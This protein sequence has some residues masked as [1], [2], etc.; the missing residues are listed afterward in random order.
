M[1]IVYLHSFMLFIVVHVLM[2]ES[3]SVRNS[4]TVVAQ[5]ADQKR[6]RKHVGHC[7][8]FEGEKNAPFYV[9]AIGDVTPAINGDLLCTRRP[10]PPRL[11][12]ILMTIAG[13][14]LGTVKC[15]MHEQRWWGVLLNSPDAVTMWRPVSC[16]TAWRS[17]AKRS[18]N[19]RWM[20]RCSWWVG[21]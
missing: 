6:W 10:P 17:A 8:Y 14:T 2:L 1:F 7:D 12:C 21:P 20:V 18:G 4:E 11:Y 3:Y 15:Y 5:R 9:V 16:S 13:M 19:G